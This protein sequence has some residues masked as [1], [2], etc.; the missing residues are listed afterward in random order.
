[1]AKIH[2]IPIGEKFNKLIILDSA[3]VIKYGNH[4]KSLVKCKCDCGNIIIC[5]LASLKNNHTKS[6][7]CIKE[8]WI[9]KVGIIESRRNYNLLFSIWSSMILRCNNPKDESYCNYG[10]R[11]IKVCCLWETGFDNFYKWALSNGYKRGLELDRI[12][13]NK[14]YYP[15]NCRWTSRSIN[16]RNKRNNKILCYNGMK[17]CIADWADYT[18]IPDGIIRNRLQLGWSIKKSLETPIKK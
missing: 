11:G 10:G 12:D 18:H 16:M 9:R 15:E 8:K 6:C 3:G 14:G 5:R 1:M 2:I 17:K 7:G 13:N 4:S